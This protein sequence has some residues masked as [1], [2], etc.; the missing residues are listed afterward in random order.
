[1]ENKDYD[2]YLDSSYCDVA[3]NGAIFEKARLLLWGRFIR[4]FFNQTE[5]SNDKQLISD[6]VFQILHK[7]NNL[8]QTPIYIGFAET[9]SDLTRSKHLNIMAN[10]LGLGVSYEEVERVDTSIIE[11]T[12]DLVC[13]DN[14]VPV[15]PHIDDET[16]IHNATDNFDDKVTDDSI[17]MLFQNRYN[18]TVSFESSIS[19]REGSTADRARKL[20]SALPCQT[21]IEIHK[22]NKRCCI[23]KDYVSAFHDF[24]DAK[25]LLDYDVWYFIWYIGSKI[26]KYLA[27]FSAVRGLLSE[28][29]VTKTSIGFKLILPHPITDFESVYTVM[30]NFQEVLKQKKQSCGPLWCN[31][32]VYQWAKEIQLPVLL[33]LD[34]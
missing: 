32:G 21:L 15:P 9:I 14:R 27:S 34:L 24:T 3:L 23:P 25:D 18:D 5:L 30:R 10:R 4:S 17:L 6:T 7:A 28:E 13:E 11:R 12:I 22:G 29:V 8:K 26:S 19:R 33:I 31:E 2:F 20:P 1:M 16:I